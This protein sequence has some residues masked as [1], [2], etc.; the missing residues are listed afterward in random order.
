LNG[1]SANVSI[2]VGLDEIDVIEIRARD[3][4]AAISSLLDGVA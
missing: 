3:D 1:D 4:V 2:V